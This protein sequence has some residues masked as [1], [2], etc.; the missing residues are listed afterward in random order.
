MIKVN[1]LSPEKKDVLGAVEAPVVSEAVSEAKLHIPAIIGATALTLGIVGF[2]YFTQSAK[3]DS[4]TQY[5]AERRARKT[6]LDNVLKTL[7]NLEKTKADLDRKV[8]V[9]SDLKA[10]QKQTVLMMDELSQVLP[11][12]V[13]LTKLSF[14]GG[15]LNISGKALTNNLI[16]DFINNLQSTN[17]FFNIRLN[18][19]QRS[20]QGGQDVFTFSINCRYKKTLEEKAV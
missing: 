5:L 18:S 6:E 12:W 11:D 9:I 19:T 4:K 3:L 13:W 7:A 2:L 15:T 8:K 10:R 14:S 16:A 1:L 20:R 17:H